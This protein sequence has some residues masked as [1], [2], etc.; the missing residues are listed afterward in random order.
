MELALEE[1]EFLKRLLLNLTVN[2]LQPDA[3]K[4][5]AIVRSISDKLEKLPMIVQE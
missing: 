2:A 5:V 4:V 3:D 1:R